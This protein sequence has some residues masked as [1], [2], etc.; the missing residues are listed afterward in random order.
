MALL[1][2]CSGFL[3]VCWLSGEGWHARYHVLL[4]SLVV[5]HGGWWG[6]LMFGG[7]AYVL[8]GAGGLGCCAGLWCVSGLS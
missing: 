2:W 3:W 7:E 6:T 8:W 1:N 4:L 5:Q